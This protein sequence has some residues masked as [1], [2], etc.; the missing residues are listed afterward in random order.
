MIILRYT[1][2]SH[3][4]RLFY[5]VDLCLKTYAKKSEPATLV[6]QLSERLPL[7][8][9]SPCALTCIVQVTRVAPHYLLKLHVTGAL[10]ITCQRCLSSFQQ[11]Y[12]SQVT[13]AVCDSEDMA[14][15]LK[16]DHECVLSHQDLVNLQDIVT[17]ELY[18][19]SPEK[20]LT[21]ADCD[22]SMCTFVGSF[23]EI[24]SQHLDCR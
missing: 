23:D 5:I 11:D 3:K 1:T 8:V 2:R 12:V 22:A 17:D 18:L 9:Q 15:Q 24:L 7:H 19:S 21:P 6:L 10:V 13:L 16:G 4:L 20:H 14:E